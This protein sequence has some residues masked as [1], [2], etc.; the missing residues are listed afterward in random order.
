MAHEH[1]AP[2]RPFLNGTTSIQVYGT[3]SDPVL[4]RVTQHARSGIPVGVHPEHLG[5]FTRPR[6]TSAEAV[7]QE[8][9]ERNMK[10]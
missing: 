8:P 5:G 1:M 9:A 4:K 6:A 2:A 3:P 10:S 7:P